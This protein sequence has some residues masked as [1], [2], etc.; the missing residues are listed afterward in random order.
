MRTCKSV[1]LVIG[2]ELTLYH[3]DGSTKVVT[4]L[5]IDGRFARASIWWPIAGQYEIGL[6]TGRLVGN[7]AT[8]AKLRKWYVDAPTLG[9]LRAARFRFDTEKKRAVL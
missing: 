4:Y 3:A 9:A 8:A 5:G 1:R 7:R 6:S 2:G